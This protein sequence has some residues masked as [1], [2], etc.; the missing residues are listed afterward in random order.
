LVL[1]QDTVP[2]AVELLGGYKTGHSG[3]T[4]HSLTEETKPLPMTT[5]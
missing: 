4:P 1:A 5:A 2:A 3:A